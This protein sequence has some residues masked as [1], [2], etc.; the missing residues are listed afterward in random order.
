VRPLDARIL[1]AFERVN[2]PR[3]VEIERAGRVVRTFAVYEGYGF[4]GV[5]DNG[6]PAKY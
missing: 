6:G 5:A 2:G 3:R 1:A 4:R